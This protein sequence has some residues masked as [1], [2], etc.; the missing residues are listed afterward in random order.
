MYRRRHTQ[1][2][3]IAVVGAGSLGSLLGGLLAREHD[4]TLVGRAPHVERVASDGLAVTGVEQFRVDPTARTDIPERADLAVVAVKSYDTAAVAEQLADCDLGVCLTVQNGMGNEATLAGALDC[5]V[6]AGTCTYGARLEG[7]GTVAFTG[8]GEVVVGAREGGASAAARRVGAAF[9]DAGID[10]VVATDM[11]RRLWAKL[12]INAAINA[13]TALARVENGAL[14]EGPGESLA[15]DA[16]RETARVA[17]EQGV[18]LSDERAVELT[19]RVVRDTA[20]NR[21]SM[22]ED[23]ADGRRTEM[24]AIN[25]Y[26]VDHA[27]EPVPVN[28]PLARLVR[29][30]AADADAE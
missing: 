24:D 21:S 15:A 26:V 17:R 12:A 10:T 20:A 8:R 23:V 19:R 7:T 13:T 2:V 1:C 25:G 27:A 22:L 4:V 14:A 28:E 5:P 16:A 9:T 11:P 30:W 6:L 3:H 29:T 18:D